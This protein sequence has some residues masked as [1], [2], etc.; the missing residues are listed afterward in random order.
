MYIL[1]TNICIYIINHK[2][3]QVFERF[4]QLNL[5]DLAISSITAC[6]LAY[7]V[8]KSGSQKNITALQKFL[9]PLTILPLGEHVVWEY[10]SIRAELEKKGQVIGSF[11][12]ML[13]AAHARQEKAILVTNNI[14][15]FERV[16]H[17]TLEN[18]V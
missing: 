12:D 10:A 15:E 11:L 4:Q 18:W 3:K 8:E 2:P 17:L 6:E 7:G 14:K 13:I 1:D 5:G 9:A 16:P